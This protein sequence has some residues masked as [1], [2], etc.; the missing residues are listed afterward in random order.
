M[1]DSMFSVSE[2]SVLEVSNFTGKVD[3]HPGTPGEINVVAT[4]WAGQESDLDQIAIEM[5]ELKNGVRITT[6]NPLK[7]NGVS[8]DLSITAPPDTRPTIL[9]G[10]G[11]IS[12]RGSGEGEC[13]FKTA[14][15]SITLELP[16]NINIEVHLSVAVGS[17]YIDHPVDGLVSK[18]V[19]N[20]IIGTGADGKLTSQVGTGRIDMIHQ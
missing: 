12:Y 1:E 18:N 9:S 5:V 8:V 2:T 17:I 13:S 14:V 19:V 7:L 3:I 10:V 20:G 4:K 15:G 11:S 6:T 16:V